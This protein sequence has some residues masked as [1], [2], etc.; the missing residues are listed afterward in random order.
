[1][2][3]REGI[4]GV[5]KFYEC[6][7]ELLKVTN[8]NVRRVFG[9]HV[10]QRGSMTLSTAELPVCFRGYDIATDGLVLQ[11]LSKTLTVGLRGTI[12]NELFWWTCPSKPRLVERLDESRSVPLTVW[13]S[14]MVIRG[15]VN[16][17]IKT[18][19]CSFMVGPFGSI[20]HHLIIKITG[21]TE[22]SW[23]SHFW[24]LVLMT[25]GTHK[26]LAALYNDI[27]PSLPVES[28]L[29]YTCI[30]ISGL[31]SWALDLGTWDHG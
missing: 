10:L 8:G 12:K 31:G 16:E 4:L 13:H 22:G 29:Q 25:G 24:K 1:M 27:R 9:Q 28:L 30:G 3:S 14:N 7:I 15:N 2:M 20:K 18:K 11:V 6:F 21:F 19:L 26:I 5:T 17:M 23:T